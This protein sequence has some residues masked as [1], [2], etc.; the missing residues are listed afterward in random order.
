MIL[1]YHHWNAYQSSNISLNVTLLE[2]LLLQIIFF[3]FSCDYISTKQPIGVERT[4]PQTQKAIAEPLWGS[5]RRQPVMLGL[6]LRELGGWTG[7]AAAASPLTWR[8]MGSVAAESSTHNKADAVTIAPRVHNSVSFRSRCSRK[9]SLEM[10]PQKKRWQSE[11]RKQPNRQCKV[12]LR[13]TYKMRI[14]KK[15]LSS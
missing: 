9:I 6:T 2:V 10:C 7:G 8:V 15:V 13:T 3:I 5:V 14:S 11:I 12:Q 4:S 1:E